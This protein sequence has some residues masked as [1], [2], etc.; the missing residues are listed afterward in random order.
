M[1]PS[2][3]SRSSAKQASFPREECFAADEVELF[4]VA[5]G[6][7]ATLLAPPTPSLRLP[8]LQ[9]CLPDETS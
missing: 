1:F 7:L 2:V 4:V 9:R 3:L 6:S 8:L 5:A